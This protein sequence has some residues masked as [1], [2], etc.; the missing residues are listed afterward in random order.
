MKRSI[1]LRYFL[2]C[3][4]IVFLAVCMHVFSVSAAKLVEDCVGL[5]LLDEGK[6]DTFKD[7]T[8]NGNDGAIKGNGIKWTKGKFGNA[9]EFPG[10]NNQYAMIEDAPSL[11]LETFTLM[12][13]VNSKKVTGKW[14]IVASKENRGPTARNYGMFLNINS[15]V[16]HYSFTNANSWR[17]YNAKTVV[18][19]GKWH[20]I[21]ATYD[22]K[23]FILYL[24][25]EVDAQTAV[26]DKPDTHDNA[27]YVGGC[28]LDASYA[29][30]GVIDEIAVF[31]RPLTADEIKDAMK[32]LQSLLAIAPLGKL[33]TTWGGIKS[34]L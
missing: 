31:K 32:G 8:E 26:S 14:Q 25:G 10:D 11:D 6:G 15:G 1:R 17:S 13:W 9:L 3:S 24:D 22:R 34:G 18:T 28:P 21:T 2:F 5:W 7:A 29:M 23:T 20:H 12:A 30:S 19:D 33:T 27:I 4:I 16:V